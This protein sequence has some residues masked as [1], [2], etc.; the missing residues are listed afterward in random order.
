MVKGAGLPRLLHANGVGDEETS[1]FGAGIGI[2]CQPGVAVQ[3]RGRDSAGMN[4]K[5]P[6]PAKYAE[7]GLIKVRTQKKGLT[8]EVNP[9]N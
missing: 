1:A 7:S 8:R 9:W 2:L 3:R 6:D 4:K 5:S